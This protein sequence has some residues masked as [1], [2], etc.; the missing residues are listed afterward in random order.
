MCG[1]VGSF[2]YSNKKL[3]KEMLDETIHRGPDDTNYY[4]NHKCMLGINRLAILD[5]KFGRQPMSINNGNLIIVFNGEIFNF[6]E[7]KEDL[8]KKGCIFK[9]LNSDTEVILQGYLIFGTEIFKKLNGMF[10]IAI[11]DLKQN[12]L[13]LCRDRS[14]IKPL[15]Y[16]FNN[17]GFFFSSEI[18]SLLKI[19]FLKKIP[20]KKAIY[21]YFGLKNIPSPQTAFENIYQLEPGQIFIVN[22][23]SCS[24]KKFWDLKKKNIYIKNNN[25]IKNQILSTLESSVIKQL[26]SDVDIGCFLSGG[27]DSSAIAA[28]AAKNYPKKLK[29]FSIVYDKNIKSKNLDTILSKKMSKIINSEH[30][31]FSLNFRNLNNNIDDAILSFDQPFAGTVSSYFLSKLASKYVKVALTGDGADELFGSYIFPRISEAKMIS[32]NRIK[33]KSFLQNSNDINNKFINYEK[34]LNM[35]IYEIK[36]YFMT[37]NE[38]RKKNYLFMKKFPGTKYNNIKYIENIYKK[39]K[40]EKDLINLALKIDFKS[41]LPD[42]VLSFVDILSMQSSLEIRPPFLDNDMIDLAFNIAG[43]KKIVNSNQKIILKESLKKILPKEVVFRRKEGFVLPVEDM[44]LK[45]NLSKIK[46]VLSKKNLSKHGYLDFN[47][48][49]HLVNNINNNSFYENNRIWI[50]YCFQQWWDKHFN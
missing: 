37:L 26:R 19:P 35:K 29:T 2:N 6:V 23:K 33:W 27:L 11:Y 34:I 30:Y 8:K 38:E 24:K 5:P 49:A 17:K 25:S 12:K 4:C 47:K 39:F 18:K 40:K 13:I 7:L 14:G 9:S 3:I 45:K 50:F 1:I 41:L 44:Y 28:L 32:N 22:E 15:F 16:N 43:N 48:L 46:N 10:A 31:E 21:N 20:N 42:Q 36:D